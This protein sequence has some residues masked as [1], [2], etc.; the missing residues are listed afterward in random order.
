MRGCGRA[1]VCGCCRR[2]ELARSRF[3]GSA[4]QR[5]VKASADENGPPR[6]L[7]SQS[8]P[9]EMPKGKGKGAKTVQVDNPL[10]KSA[11]ETAGE[12][13]AATKIQARHR[14]NKAR[15]KHGKK[16][17]KK[18][19]PHKK[20][21]VSRRHHKPEPKDMKVR[22]LL[23]WLA[24]TAHADAVSRRQRARSRLGIYARGCSRC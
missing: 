20:G 15:K 10:N 22:Q 24:A 3:R 16:G 2:L 9:G 13:A 19:Q 7:S 14:G 6:T 8:E 5:R 12:T 11:S 17:K 21:K 4:R 1:S 23:C 18:R